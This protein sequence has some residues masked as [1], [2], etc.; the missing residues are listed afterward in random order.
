[1]LDQMLFYILVAFCHA[2]PVSE[3]SRQFESS[4][5]EFDSHYRKQQQNCTVGRGVDLSEPLTVKLSDGIAKVSNSQGL[6][7]EYS[8]HLSGT[9]KSGVGVKRII[10]D[11]L[12]FAIHYGESLL[13]VTKAKDEEALASLDQ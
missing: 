10:I 8:Y 6:A 12:P 13:K 2:A 4:Y 3:A 1:M 5:L 9:L 7:F 11:S